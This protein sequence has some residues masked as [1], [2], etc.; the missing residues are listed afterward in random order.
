MNPNIAQAAPDFL[1]R[2]RLTGQEVE[3]HWPRGRGV[4]GRTTGDYRGN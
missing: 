3:A 2:V 4:S 1:D